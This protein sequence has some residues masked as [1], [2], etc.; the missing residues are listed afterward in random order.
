LDSATAEGRQRINQT[1]QRLQTS[2]KNIV[3][4]SALCR[5]KI[6]TCVFLENGQGWTD[7][8]TQS[9]LSA[10]QTIKADS[11]VQEVMLYS[12][13]RPSLQ[14][15]AEHLSALDNA[16]LQTLAVAVRELGFTVSVSYGCLLAFFC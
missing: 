16:A 11:S 4:A 13:A 14:A 5:T 3:L 6:Q 15:H 7:Q 12:L 10:L 2:V 9:Y 1:R 8:E